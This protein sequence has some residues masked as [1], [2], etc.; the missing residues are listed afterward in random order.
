[1]LIHLCRSPR[2]NDVVTMLIHDPED[3]LHLFCRLA[4]AVDYLGVA[5]AELTVMVYASE[6]E[7]GVGEVTQ[8]LHG[9]LNRY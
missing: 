9:L 1:M 6:T 2:A 5:G 3:G 7:I 4:G 8:I